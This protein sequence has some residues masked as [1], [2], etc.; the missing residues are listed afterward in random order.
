MASVAE[1]LIRGQQEA[2]KASVEGLGES[3]AGVAQ[4][5]EQHE[6]QK[7]Q[8]AQRQEQLQQAKI[9][10]FSNTILSGTK[11]KDVKSRN[12][13]FSKFL[14]KQKTA[15]GLDEV[16]D[17]DSINFI[18]SSDENLVKFKGLIS[19]V[20]RGELDFRQAVGLVNDPAQFAEFE[21]GPGETQ[22]ILEAEKGALGREFAQEKFARTEARQERESAIREARSVRR[23]ERMLT[24]E[25]EG[26]IQKLATFIDKSGFPETIN[27]LKKIDELV[28]GLDVAELKDL[29]GFGE[30]GNFPEFLISPAGKELRAVSGELRNSILKMRSG[31]AVTPEEANRLLEE[32]GMSQGILPQFK[33]DKQFVNGIKRVRDKVR[34][35]LATREAGFNKSVNTEFQ[36]RFEERTGNTLS[37][38]DPFLRGK[39]ARKQKA[40]LNLPT[41]EQFNSASLASQEALAKKINMSLDELKKK[42]GVK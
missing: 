5:A 27:T 22:E 36:T 12:Q 13:F 37:S 2:T 11:I 42:I 17:Q 3:I 38:Q 41:A 14:P 24:R 9:E 8:F 34:D 26:D 33:S 23:E 10:K 19:R 30:T 16:F 21:I 28:G 31:G 7:Q 39:S 15:L 6:I 32:L 40:K 18:T 1:Q 29:P 4:R 35:K 25:D 20:Q